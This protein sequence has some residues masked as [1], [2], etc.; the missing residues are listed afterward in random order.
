MCSEKSPQPLLHEY[1]SPYDLTKR[2]GEDLVLNYNSVDLQ[3]VSLR[4]GGIISNN[5][6]TITQY[7]R[8]PIFFRFKD[9]IKIDTNCGINIAHALV[10]VDNKLK[11]GKTNNIGGNYYYYTGKHIFVNTISE[12]V[13]SNQKKKIV[14]LPKI[15]LNIFHKLPK[16][17]NRFNI[18]HLLCCASYEQTF[19]NTLFF[20]TFQF[21]EKHDLFEIID[22]IYPTPR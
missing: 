15:I 3:T 13:A 6:D 2:M 14:Y 17:I 11:S 8:P 12:K 5:N 9:D 1:R 16:T 7:F 19:D 10:A 20:E 18:V 4:V 22:N 21:E